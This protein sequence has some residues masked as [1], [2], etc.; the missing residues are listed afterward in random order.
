MISLWR[1]GWQAI[2][3]RARSLRADSLALFFALA[4][5]RMPRL[6]RWLVWGIVAYALSPIDLIP[7]FIPVIGFLD[8]LILL[9]L[10]IAFAIRCIPAPV[11]VDARA[12]AAAQPQRVKLLAGAVLI[13]LVWLGLGGL[14]GWYWLG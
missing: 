9:P 12:R 11:M 13:G 10:A 7:D 4:D 2:W 8:E 6:A 5:P 14:I 3:Q 1:R